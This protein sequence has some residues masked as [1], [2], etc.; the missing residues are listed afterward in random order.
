MP[1]GPGTRIGSYEVKA[2][3]GEGGMGKVWRAHHT[4]L[5]RDDALKM[6]P[7]AFLA[8]PDRLARF[9]REAQVLASLNHSNIAHV[10]GLEETD[11][12]KALVM[13]LVEGETLA[14]RIV[15]GRIPIDEALSIARQI[16]DALEAAHSHGI[17]HRDLKPANIKLRPDG[18]VKVL[19]FGLAKALDRPAEA[20]HYGGT[21][22]RSVRL[23]P[24]LTQSPTITSPAMTTAGVILGTAAY[25][26]PEQA[27]GM[28]VDKRADMWAFGCVLYEMLT[29]RRPFAGNTPMEVIA[30]VL[31][32]Q[33]DW[34]ALPPGVP[35]GAAR[36]LR[37]CLEKNVQR[38]LRDAGDARL[39]LEDR[40]VAGATV[41]TAGRSY[42]WVAAALAAASAI[43]LAIGVAF[44][45]RDRDV[46]ELPVVRTT[47]VLPP[48]QSFETGRRA[49]T[50]SP[51]GQQIAYSSRAGLNI[52]RLDAFESR[53]IPG[54]ANAINPAFSP[55]GQR[56]A[57][58]TAQG[59]R[60]IDVVTGSAT[61]LR[62]PPANQGGILG[63]TSWDEHGLMVTQGAGGVYLFPPGSTDARRIVELS[64]GEAVTSAEMLP[65]GEHILMT[66]LAIT[67]ARPGSASGQVVVQ[68]LQTGSRT[69]VIESGSDARYVPSGH[70]VYAANGALYAMEFDV[71]TLRARGEPR[72]VVEGIRATNV[73]N[74]T[75][76]FA[77]SDTGTLVYVP[78]Q[79]VSPALALDLVRTDR[80]GGV[81]FLHLPIAPYET[82]RV[83][84]DGGSIAVGADDGK[85]GNIWIHDLAVP[86]SA[87]KLTVG[88]GRHRFPVWS[89]D[90]RRIAF[91]SNRDG[92][93]AVF[94]QAAN[95]SD[96]PVR[97]TTAEAGAVHTPE[98]WSPDG[99]T[100]LFT[101]AKD[102][103][104]R[105]WRL[106]VSSGRLEPFAGVA[107]STPT[108]AAFSPD[109]NW[110][111]YN[112]A[113]ANPAGDITFVQPFPP[114]G[115]I[116]QV[117]SN[118]DGHHPVWSRDGRELFY[119]PGPSQI[120]VVTV[121]PGASFTF[122]PPSIIAPAGLM[123]PGTF[124]RNF[125]ILLDGSGFIGR[126][127][128]EDE[129]SRLG[130]PPR[131]H[132][133]TNWFEDLKRRK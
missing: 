62:T 8:D 121:T 67:Q 112:I 130:A 128:A 77:V 5:R 99:G 132:V 81:R 91:Q 59:V 27:Q 78:G 120:A 30:H 123:G 106:S 94:A 28:A 125:D 11:G 83:S 101:I 48:G 108:A 74:A 9:E 23:Q 85:E 131:L 116:Y 43:A 95:G 75:T 21:D 42:W 13:E 126:Q 92:D 3:I 88:P 29:G 97:L 104:Y 24:D 68:T 19:D 14:D 70:I 113:A 44:G 58:W 87:R 38:R 98:S 127:V 69:T 52:R 117:S 36:V 71:E 96:A 105:L 25:M 41:R 115:A 111:A 7:D 76:H 107:S 12:V 2:L 47:I 110:V 90:G 45:R 73:I 129:E 122:S 89:P 26:A 4:G 65:G 114:T 118:D 60:S 46:A 102:G 22:G 34:T 17:V 37:R 40:S 35:D 6:L 55:D 86:S 33:P 51:D 79:A 80:K 56:I 119:V 63:S 15:H 1:I 82:P 18:I 72:A 103:T 20:G 10:Y 53:L 109:G 50:I 64:R 66:M 39:D 84:P 16:A 93:I 100:L 61:P 133:V 57:V 49:V 54:S 124:N 31:A 32:S